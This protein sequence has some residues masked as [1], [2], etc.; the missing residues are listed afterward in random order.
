[1]AQQN[2]MSQQAVNT[3]PKTI[4][5][6]PV[7]S[8]Q[9]DTQAQKG[10]SAS[11]SVSSNL[12]QLLDSGGSYLTQARQQGQSQAARR[13]LGGSSI[14][15]QAAQGAAIGAAAPIAQ[16]EAQIKESQRA[17]SAEISSRKQIAELNIEAQKELQKGQF[18][19]T[20]SQAELDRLLDQ[21]K[22]DKAIAEQQRAQL[23]QLDSQRAEAEKN[24]DWQTAESLRQE[25]TAVEAQLRDLE[26]QR[27]QQDK[28]IAEQQ[29]AQDEAIAEQQRAQEESQKFQSGESELDRIQEQEQLKDTVTQNMKGQYN[30]SLQSIL[31]ESQISI[32]AIETATDIKPEDKDKMINNIIARQQT[33]ISFMN[34]LYNNMPEWEADWTVLPPPVPP[35]G[36]EGDEKAEADAAYEQA[37]SDWSGSWQ[38]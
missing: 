35:T 16:Q 22:Q 6:Q 2:T 30:T 1:M 3:K 12:N 20:G 9:G 24:R 27:E 11:T 32:N 28:A 18:D 31:R 8:K 21:Q 25:Q 26:A 10:I 34:N 36:L 33:D 13:G 19:F 15:A 4:A 29:R 7:V 5:N 14:A 23:E 17:Q 38:G 37:L